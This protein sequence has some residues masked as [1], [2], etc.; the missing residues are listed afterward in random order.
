MSTRWDERNVAP[1]CKYCNRYCQ[2][3][4]Y[5]F[6]QYL[7][8]KLAEELYIESKKIRKFDDVELQDMIAH[9]TELNKSFL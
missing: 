4:Q 8:D 9:Y 6:S 3:Q 7:G 2:G 1:Q 5:L